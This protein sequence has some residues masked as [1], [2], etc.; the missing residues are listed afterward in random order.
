[1][2]RQQKYHAWTTFGF[3]LHHPHINQ[4]PQQRLANSQNPRIFL[5]HHV[6]WSFAA[7]SDWAITSS[8]SSSNEPAYGVHITPRPSGTKEQWFWWTS[9]I[10]R[11]WSLC[12]PPAASS[13]PSYHVAVSFFQSELLP[14]L[15]TEVLFQIGDPHLPGGRYNLLEYA[16]LYYATPSTVCLFWR[17]DSQLS[18]SEHLLFLRI[19]IQ[20]RR[21]QTRQHYNPPHKSYSIKYKT[22]YLCFLLI[23]YWKFQSWQVCM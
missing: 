23:S 12:L 11:T 20:D 15:P 8:Q 17:S 18:C 3:Q 13:P 9:T 6:G 21:H 4:L 7:S 2:Q 5:N 22:H 10:R 14:K 16:G 19:Q 1:M